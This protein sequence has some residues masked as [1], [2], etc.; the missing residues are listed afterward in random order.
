MVIFFMFN[1][2]NWKGHVYKNDLIGVIVNGLLTSIAVG[3]LA[4][5]IDYLFYL[6]NFSMSLGLI[7]L[8]F[9]VGFRVRKGYFSYHPLYP[10]LAIIFMVIG[11]FIE[12]LTYYAFLMGFNNILHILS[13]WNFY[14][15]FLIFPVYYFYLLTINF[16]VLY[17]FLGIVDLLFFI[18]AIYICFKMSGGRLK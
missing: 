5:A 6:V 2:E 7:L 4:G 13:S 17:I 18:I 16:K 10:L 8:S 15:N 1:L 12:M 14:L 11:L 3:V 9:S